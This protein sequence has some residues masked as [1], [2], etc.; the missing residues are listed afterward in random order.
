MQKWQEQNKLTA[1]L[2]FK[3]CKGKKIEYDVTPLKIDQRFMP[4]IL[5]NK[6]KKLALEYVRWLSCRF[7]KPDYE[8]FRQLAISKDYVCCFW[9][10]VRSKIFNHAI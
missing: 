5:Q 9:H 7:G 6:E 1:Y 8:I 4:R 2:T 10:T 3:L